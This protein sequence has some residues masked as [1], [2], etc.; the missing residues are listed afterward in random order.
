MARQTTRYDWADEDF[1]ISANV[2][3][4]DNLKSIV[5]DAPKGNQAIGAYLSRLVKTGKITTDDV[6]F[7]IESGAL[8]N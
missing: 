4:P 7:L 8:Q 5:S 6:T 3:L 2:D 1:T